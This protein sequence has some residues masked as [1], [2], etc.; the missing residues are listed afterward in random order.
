MTERDYE[1]NTWIETCSE[2]GAEF[3]GKA[4]PEKQED[5]PYLILMD[6][7]PKFHPDKTITCRRRMEDF[8]PWER[9]EGMDFWSREV[10]GDRTCSFCGGMHP[11]DFVKI[12]EK[13]RDGVEGYRIDQSDKSYKVYVHQPDVKNA[14]DGAIKFY[15]YHITAIGDELERQK[16]LFAVALAKSRELFQQELQRVRERLLSNGN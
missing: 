8:D 12:M 16:R 9:K 3:E 15:K 6:H 2:C 13:I 5:N 4:K 11:D 10:N 14:D 1:N 7:F